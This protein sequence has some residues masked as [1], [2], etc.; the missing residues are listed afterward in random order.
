MH[1]QDVVNNNYKK[2]KSAK[3]CAL[4]SKM[5]RLFSSRDAGSALHKLMFSELIARSAEHL[6]QWADNAAI[7]WVFRQ[8]HTARFIFMYSQHTVCF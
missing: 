3:I 8:A 1:S 4:S 6:K 2:L 7:C 5:E